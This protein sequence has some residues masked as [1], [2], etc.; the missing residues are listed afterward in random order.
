MI[1]HA[2]EELGVDGAAFGVYVPTGETCQI[3]KPIRWN[4]IA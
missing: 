3:L 1:G 4:E 2:V